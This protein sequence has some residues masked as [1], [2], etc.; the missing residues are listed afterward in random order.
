MACV[1]MTSSAACTVDLIDFIDWTGVECLNQDSSHNIVNA[2]KQVDLI[3][4][5]DWTG[6]ECLNQD[7]SHNIVNA[8]KQA[9]TQILKGINSY[10]SSLKVPLSENKN[11]PVIRSVPFTITPIIMYSEFLISL[12]VQSGSRLFGFI[13]AGATLGQLFGSLFAASM[14]WLGPWQDKLLIPWLMMK[15][16]PQMETM[17][18][19]QKYRF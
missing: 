11:A 18:S 15:F 6:V 10:R 19:G 13:G 3:D 12:L 17:T 14:A 9:M 1:A 8:L 2:L 5:I 7:S 16:L 4:F